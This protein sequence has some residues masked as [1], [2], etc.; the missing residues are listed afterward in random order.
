[1]IN[2]E[3]MDLEVDQVRV[4]LADARPELIS[5]QRGRCS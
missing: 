1:M 3:E 2:A 4:T 5:I